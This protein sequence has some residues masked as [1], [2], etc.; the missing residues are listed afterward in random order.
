MNTLTIVDLGLKDIKRIMQTERLSFIPAIQASEESV[1]LRLRLGHIMLGAEMAGRLVGKIC[2]SYANFSPND[3]EGF[4]KTFQ[5]FSH[6]PRPERHNSVFVY[7]LDVIP[8]YRGDKASSL[9]L[10]TMFERVK[11]DGCAYLICDGR[12]SSYNG[13]DA[14]EEQVRQNPDFKAAIDR[15]LAGGPFPT[16]KELMKDPTLALYIR[17]AGGAKFLWVI[18]DFLPE[19]KPAGGIRVIMYK[20]L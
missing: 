20:E 18:P 5:E 1:R 6:Q 7:N 10:R 17:V 19:D 13:S 3:F 14:K 12:P 16:D 15:F 2:F 9:L 11:K 4:P 8:S